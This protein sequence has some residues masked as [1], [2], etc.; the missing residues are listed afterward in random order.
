[1][2]KPRHSRVDIEEEMEAAPVGTHRGRGW[3]PL[4]TSQPAFMV[5]N[6]AEA[7]VWE[8]LKDMRPPMYDGNTL[9]LDRFLGKLDHV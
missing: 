2:E 9:N 1:M 3:E 6:A 5:S 4:L 7:A 8:H